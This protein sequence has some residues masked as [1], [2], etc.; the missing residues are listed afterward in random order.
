MAPHPLAALE[1][2][3]LVEPR[4]ETLLEHLRPHGAVPLHDRRVPGSLANIDHVVIAPSGVWIV[5]AKNFRGRI[6]RRGR[7]HDARLF[8]DRQDR[9]DLVSEMTE[10]YDAVRYAVANATVPIHRVLCFTGS[11][12]PFFA[13]PFALEGVWVTW[14]RALVET[15][16][17]AA[18]CGL[19]VS[20]LT[21]DLATRFPARA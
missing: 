14:P 21:D 13:K 9:S 17:G 11:E 3:A 16:Q 12:W 20:E 8:V 15:I 2:D 4:V 18:A 5:D 1:P 10:Q 7:R 19:P 6:E